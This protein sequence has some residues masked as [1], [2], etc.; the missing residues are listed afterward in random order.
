MQQD[1]TPADASLALASAPAATGRPAAAMA[2]GEATV[3]LPALRLPRLRAALPRWRVT[4]SPAALA[5]ALAVVIAG[6]LGVVAFAASGPSVLAPHSVQS[7][8]GWLSGPLSYVIPKTLTNAVTVGQL[9]SV[10]V[11]GMLLAYGV[12]LAGVR[13]LSMRT[14]AIT[15]VAL[16]AILLLS[17]P[18]QLTDMFNYLG[19]ARLGALHGLNPYTHVIGQESFDPVFRFAS[20]LNLRSPYGPLFT[21]ITYPLAFVSLPLAYWTMKTLTIVL[22]LAFVALVYHC[23]RRLGRDP[24]VAVVF[25]AL[26]PIYLIYEVAGFHN[27]FFML[28]PMMA[29]IALTLARRDRSSGAVLMLAVA[30]KFTAVLLLPFLL[31]A[32]HARRRQANVLAGAVLATIPLAALSLAL[33]GFSLPN[34]AQ[35]S[36]LLTGFS[37]PN[38]LG[39]LVNIGGATPVLLKVA[40]VGVVLVVA[41]QFLR[42]RDWMAGAGWSTAALIASLGWLMPWYVVW[43]LPLAALASSVRLRR[44]ALVLTVYLVL[45][46]IPW[47]GTYLSQHG[48]NPLATPAGQAT[49][50]LQ[51]KLAG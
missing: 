1:S 47:T 8:P 34:L 12:L 17:P 11:V 39:W 25:V 20:W 22:S 45:A 18:L 51:H 26:N 6:T 27:D 24:R 31:V 49:G 42:N 40:E 13:R 48:I 44:V 9:F 29:A 36:A 35:Q 50:A 2:T 4:P 46:F 3:R 37:I 15:V 7:F 19:Y 38:F 33:F 28:V 41:H 43:I 21:A 14:I 5:A 23:A 10:V 30:V 32:A 16:H